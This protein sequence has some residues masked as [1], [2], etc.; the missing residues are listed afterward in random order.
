MRH[1]RAQR[2]DET[3]PIAMPHA[4]ARTRAA[5]AAAMPAHSGWDTNL[6]H[7]PRGYFLVGLPALV[8]DRLPPLSWVS[9]AVAMR[10]GSAVPLARAASQAFL[11]SR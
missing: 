5:P 10:C 4:S 3:N 7:A 6:I 11:C 9:P 2:A 1:P 8:L